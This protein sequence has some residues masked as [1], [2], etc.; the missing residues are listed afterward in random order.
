VKSSGFDSLD[1]VLQDESE[2]VGATLHLCRS[3]GFA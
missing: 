3:D 2:V 1:L